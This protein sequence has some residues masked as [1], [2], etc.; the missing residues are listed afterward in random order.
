MC[1]V[2]VSSPLGVRGHQPKEDRAPQ[3]T[4]VILK[5]ISY[6]EGFVSGREGVGFL[7][8]WDI[9]GMKGFSLS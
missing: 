1:V 2:V 4:I 7:V 9:V 3:A 6:S 5:T 8:M